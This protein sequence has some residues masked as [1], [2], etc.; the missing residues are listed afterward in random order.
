MPSESLTVISFVSL[1]ASCIVKRLQ[2]ALASDS[3]L[4]DLALS[5][6]CMWAEMVSYHAEL[7]VGGA[8]KPLVLSLRYPSPLAHSYGVRAIACISIHRQFRSRLISEAVIGPPL[9]TLMRSKW[10]RVRRCACRIACN[11]SCDA[12]GALEL[13]RV[14]GM[15]V[16]MSISRAQSFK[17]DIMYVGYAKK[18]VENMHAAWHLEEERSADEAMSLQALQALASGDDD[19][20]LAQIQKTG[21]GGQTQHIRQRVAFPQHV[22]KSSVFNSWRYVILAERQAATTR[23]RNRAAGRIQGSIRQRTTERERKVKLE[24]HYHAATSIQSKVRQRSAMH[25]RKEK[26][27]AA[28]SIQSNVRGRATRKKQRK[29]REKQTDDVIERMEISINQA[30]IRLSDLQQAKRLRLKDVFEKIDVSGDG[31]ISID[32]FGNHLHSLKLNVG[33]EDL[34]EFFDALDPTGGGLIDYKDFKESFSRLEKKAQEQK[35]EDALANKEAL[36]SFSRRSD[37]LVEKASKQLADKAKAIF[38]AANVADVFDIDSSGSVNRREF[39]TAAKALGF[40]EAEA[41]L[42]FDRMDADASDSLEHE[43]LDRLYR[44]DVSKALLEDGH[45][46]G[47]EGSQQRAIADEMSDFVGPE[48]VLG[49]GETSPPS[50]DVSVLLYEV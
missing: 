21:S 48:E 3:E 43:E 13:M 16:G 18:A 45:R 31:F 32:E 25:D 20:A 27:D 4:Q 1:F 50:Q 34:R 5:M 35:R 36:S 2:C 24:S 29:E 23:Q 46:S 30:L 7:V 22:L 44:S 42:M 49:L 8:L 11:L 12:A 41:S 19:E 10:R 37:H 38:G 39:T 9:F 33:A 40:G 26:R 6:L 14:G 15:P 28:I 17:E 47:S